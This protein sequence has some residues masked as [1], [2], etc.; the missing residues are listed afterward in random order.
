MR[1]VSPTLLALGAALA[2]RGPVTGPVAA[3]PAPRWH[4]GTSATPSAARGTKAPTAFRFELPARTELRTL[5]RESVMATAERVACL[6]GRIET[7]TVVVERVR[8]LVPV[9]ADSMGISAKQSIDECGPPDFQ[10]TVHTHIALY[11]GQH[12]YETFSGADRGVMML[13]ARQW[14]TDGMFCV[15]YTH[16]TAHCELQGPTGMFIE[17]AMTY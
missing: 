10:G 15:L 5:W 12:P 16:D 13:W 9:D 7:D 3:A 1:L 6:G 17:H 8:P 4:V 14:K 2:A 11:D